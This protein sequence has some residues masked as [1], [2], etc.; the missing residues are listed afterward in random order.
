[1]EGD[2]ADHFGDVAAGVLVIAHS[3][4]DEGTHLVG[5]EVGE[6]VEVLVRHGDEGGA[7]VDDGGLTGDD[8]GDS[9]V[10]GR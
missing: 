2:G 4:T 7:G 6:G 10:S 5:E 3:S 9:V 1:M 8:E